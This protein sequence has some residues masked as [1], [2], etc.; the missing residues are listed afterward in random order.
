MCVLLLLAYVGWSYVF[1]KC[2]VLHETGAAVLVGLVAGYI[3]QIAFG[4]A[5]SFSY[6]MFSYILLPMVIF[7]AGFNLDKHHFF[8]HGGYILALGITGSLAFCYYACLR[9]GLGI[10]LELW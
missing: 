10:N 5:A 6:E 1:E 2:H 4:G 8:R 3:M 7:A 9:I